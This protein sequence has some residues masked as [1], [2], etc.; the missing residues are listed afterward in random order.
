[1]WPRPAPAAATPVGAGA[2]P[3]ASPVGVGAGS[4][5]SSQPLSVGGGAS[6]L[7]GGGASG[8]AEPTPPPPG[9]VTAEGPLK[10]A[11]GELWEKCRKAKLT[12]IKVLSLRLF[13]ATD[14]FKMLGSLNAEKNC[15]K[16]VT[17]SGAYETASGGE[18]ELTFRGSPDDALPVKDFLVPQLNAA[19]AAKK[20]RNVDATFEL[21]FDPLL[22]LAG[23]APEK[24]AERL[25][26]FASGAAYVAATAQG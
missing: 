1:M 21:I 8:V 25:G 23:D 10:Q 16:T 6:A 24:L 4:G 19:A 5:S 13:D 11:L 22:S 9:A 3:G 20:E 17:L 15:K 12:E 14:A 2:S 18:M 7:T 26:K